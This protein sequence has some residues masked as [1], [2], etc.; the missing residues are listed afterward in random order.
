M[1]NLNKGENTILTSVEL[2]CRKNIRIV[3]KYLIDLKKEK[4]TGSSLV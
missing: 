3:K 4:K 1:S 2:K